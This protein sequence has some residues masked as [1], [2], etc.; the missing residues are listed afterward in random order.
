MEKITPSSPGEGP[1]D[2]TE[3]LRALEAAVEA[4]RFRPIDFIGKRY[5]TK[6]YID[7]ANKELSEKLATESKDYDESAQ[8]AE[9]EFTYVLSHE[10]SLPGCRARLASEYDD[11]LNGVDI[12]CDLERDDGKK[13]VFGIDISTATSRSAIDA[14]FARGDRARGQVP[15]GCSF[16]KFYDDGERVACLKGVPRFVLGVSP[17]FCGQQEYFDK[18]HLQDDGTVSHKPDPDLS[19]NI[20]SSLFIQSTTL[21]KELSKNPSGEEHTCD[22]AID[23]CKAVRLAA[24]KGLVRLMGARNELDF[25]Q[26]LNKKLMEAMKAQVNGYTD[27]CYR[28]I[29]AESRRRLDLINQDI[30]A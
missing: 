24:K 15:A 26:K 3:K 17:L 7:K 4:D 21:A 8:L 16:V 14:K 13:Y 29:I 1:N 12:V 23:T 30:A 5:Y 27:E 28:G 20:L 25:H 19:F 9:W 2:Y 11:H 10:D 18:F 6:E 22:R